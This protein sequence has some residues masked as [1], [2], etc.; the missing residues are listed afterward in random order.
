MNGEKMGWLSQT[1][2]FAELIAQMTCIFSSGKGSIFSHRTNVVASSQKFAQV[3][4]L[5]AKEPLLK[6]C[7]KICSTKTNYADG[8]KVRNECP[9]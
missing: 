2:P 8:S 6:G 3:E 1:L 5:I 7:K 4:G 9:R